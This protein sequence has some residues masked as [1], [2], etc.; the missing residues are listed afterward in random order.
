[1]SEPEALL[2]HSVRATHWLD[3]DA[4]R[5]AVADRLPDLDLTVAD[6]PAASAAAIG[7]VE[8]LLSSFAEPSLLEAA[9]S[10]RWVQAL[11]AGID[12]LPLD[13]LRERDVVVT[14]AAGAHAGPAAEQA[15]GYMLAFERGLDR[16]IA[17]RERGVWERFTGGELADR[18]L[19]VVGLGA[20]GRRAAELASAVGMEVVGTKRDPD[21]AVAPAD[22]VYPPEG[23]HDVLAA[24]DHVLL[25]CPLTAD[26]RG[27]IGRAELGVM[28]ED[29]VLL[30]VARG[31]VV[32]EAALTTALQQGV[33]G[34]AALDVFE[35]EPLPSESTLWDLSN[36]ILTPH[37]A[38]SS[39][40]LP[41]RIAEIF[42]DNYDAFAAGA[43][44]RMRTRE[45]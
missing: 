8:I 39:P 28:R 23:L 45:L 35:T 26:T 34:G 43:L 6:T 30:N 32:D 10:L 22:R 25:A 38:G 31:P 11:S 19:G 2:H 5:A 27:L 12:S 14:S 24:A 13:P 3:A 7:E 18:T 4:L 1:M 16:A 42:A 44:D 37:N 29:A 15:L 36:V 33:I 21:E 20:I 9:A 17:A 41:D 40:R